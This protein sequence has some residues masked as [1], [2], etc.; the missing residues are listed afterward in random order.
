MCARAI[1]SCNR[2][3]DN[4][5]IAILHLVE[6]MKMVD[7]IE[8]DGKNIDIHVI[9]RCAESR[10]G[11]TRARACAPH[12]TAPHARTHAHTHATTIHTRTRARDSMAVAMALRLPPSVPPPLPLPLT[13][14]RA[15]Y[16]VRRDVRRRGGSKR[17][18]ERLARS[19]NGDGEARACK[20]ASERVREREKEN[21]SVVERWTGTRERERESVSC[22]E[23]V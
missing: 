13:E 1:E 14:S 23:R 6:I 8:R 12:R 5:K 21:P 10:N 16:T 22:R 7:K 4:E 15:Q 2:F 20:G 9:S 17:R 18:Q 11:R 19:S 3:N